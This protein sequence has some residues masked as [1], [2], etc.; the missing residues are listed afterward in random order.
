MLFVVLFIFI[1]FAIVLL[2]PVYRNGTHLHP[3]TEIPI[4]EYDDHIEKL[5]KAKI[6]PDR[7]YIEEM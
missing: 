1:L 2:L 5:K 3:I 4:L 6:E 7:L